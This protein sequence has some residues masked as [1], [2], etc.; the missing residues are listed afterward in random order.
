TA[1]PDSAGSQ[2]FIC[3]STL[4]KLDGDYAAF[5]QVLAGMDVVDLIASAPNGGLPD[6]RPKSKQVMEEVFFVTPSSGDS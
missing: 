2:F 1:E 3:V 5:G 6:N 4:P